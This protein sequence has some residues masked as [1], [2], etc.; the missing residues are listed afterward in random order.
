[1]IFT[2][3][4]QVSQVMSS[5]AGESTALNEIGGAYQYTRDSA[6]TGLQLGE[7]RGKNSAQEE[8]TSDIILG[9]NYSNSDSFLQASASVSSTGSS[10]GNNST[11][12]D[13][14]MVE[15]GIDYDKTPKPLI[16]LKISTFFLFIS[17]IT[18]ASV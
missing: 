14:K 11:E 17:L 15:E 4:Q 16:F 13:I 2:E 1:V 5:H 9:K 8:N 6:N 3:N 18:L 12:S 10:N 7:A